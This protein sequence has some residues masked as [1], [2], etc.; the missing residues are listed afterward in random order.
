MDIELSYTQVGKGEPLFLLHGNGEDRRFFEA[1]MEPLA[2]ERRV[3]AVDTR[4]HG[5]S[6]RGQAPFS[7]S[8][9]ADDLASLMDHLRLESADILGFSDGGNVALLFAL[10][11]PRRVRKLIVNGANLYPTGMRLGVW[12]AIVILFAVLSVAAP[13]SSKAAA[14][15]DLIGLMA[16]QPHIRPMQLHDLTVP[17]L[18]IAGTRDL[19]RER[20][21]R[22]IARSIPGAQLVLLAGGHTVAQK[23]SEAYNAAVL[24]FL[25]DDETVALA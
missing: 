21:T 14:R 1:Q 8:Q 19:I 15:R 13:F 9:F 22:L 2:K 5:Q 4:G 6:S 23:R 18:V 7:L 20:H 24:A 25:A 11:Y 16:T 3:I 12:L 17:T 10:R